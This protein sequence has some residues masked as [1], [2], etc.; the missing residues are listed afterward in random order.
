MNQRLVNLSKSLSYVLRHGAQKE[1]LPLRSDGYALITDVLQLRGFRKYR[2][3]FEEIMSVVENNEK[4]R[5]AVTGIDGKLHIR[6]NQGHTIEVKD[7]ELQKITDPFLYPCVI[8]GTYVKAWTDI[9]KK[10]LSRM[11]RNHI[12]MT[13]GVYGSSEVISGMRSSSEILVYIDIAKAME[14]KIE[15]FTSANNVVLTEG[16]EGFLPSKYF[17]H[18][19]KM[20]EMEPFDSDFP[21]KLEEEKRKQQPKEKEE[22]KEPSQTE[23]DNQDLPSQESKTCFKCGKVGH[24]AKQCPSKQKKMTNLLP[25]SEL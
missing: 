8:H 17:T 12:H 20:P 16:I 13:T 18:V 11:N 25:N 3:T 5:Y 7:L 19:I 9:K 23:T 10:G 15:F 2:Y 6:A 21:N 24:V 22:V 4:K 14:D 1:K